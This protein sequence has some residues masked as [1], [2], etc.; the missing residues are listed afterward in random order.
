MLNEDNMTCPVLLLKTPFF[1]VDG[2]L[3]NF[4]VI[5]SPSIW[6]PFTYL[7]QPLHCSVLLTHSICGFGK[8]YLLHVLGMA[9]DHDC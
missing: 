9:K 3:N 8:L 6:F 7:V 1:Y 5:A 4:L 2:W